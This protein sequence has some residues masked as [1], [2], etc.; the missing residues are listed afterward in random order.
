M[1]GRS[2]GVFRVQVEVMRP[3]HDYVLKQALPIR[4]AN[5]ELRTVKNNIS[6]TPIIPFTWIGTR[7]MR[8]LSKRWY[9][10][11]LHVSTM[12]EMMR[13]GCSIYG[14]SDYLV[15]QDLLTRRKIR[16]W[17]GPTSLFRGKTTRW[18][19]Q[20]NNKHQISV[21][22]YQES[23]DGKGALICNPVRLGK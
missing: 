5:I 17:V 15:F 8:I 9:M 18:Q 4:V 22:L 1:R 3:R 2:R 6:I 19:H 10:I 7:T 23:K 13:K 14:Y 12:T 16:P 20:A 11:R 21:S